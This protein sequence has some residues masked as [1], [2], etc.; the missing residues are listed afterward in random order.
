MSYKIC[1]VSYEGKYIPLYGHP[2]KKTDENVFTVLIGKN[3]SGKSRVLSAIANTLCSV[4]V[5][6]KLLKRDIGAGSKYR[7]E[8][9]CFSIEIIS[10]NDIQKIEVNGRSISNSF[11]S[12]YEKNKICPKKIITVSTS[13]FDKFPEE[14]VYFSSKINDDDYSFYNYYG[15]NESS[16]NKAVLSL[17]E[18]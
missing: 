5:G 14:R 6:N 16:K 8:D 13:P 2:Y 9:H 4:F 12:Q 15:L 3:G 17:I 1:N 18:K 11:K 10:G 7:Q